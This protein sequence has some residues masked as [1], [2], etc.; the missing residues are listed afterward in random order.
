MHSSFLQ[1]YTLTLISLSPVSNSE[2]HPAIHRWHP[3]IHFPVHYTRTQTAAQ[4]SIHAPDERL[5][6]TILPFRQLPKS[7]AR[8]QKKRKQLSTQ[9]IQQLGATI[10]PRGSTR[11]KKSDFPSAHITKIACN[12]CTVTAITAWSS[13]THP[14]RSS[15]HTDGYPTVRPDHPNMRISC[16]RVVGHRPS[17]DQPYPPPD[18]RSRSSVYP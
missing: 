18:P 8:K 6:V 14:D 9:V 17:R 13:R 2:I 12:A 10:L 15:P 4:K 5:F 16:R 11:P 1:G 7:S 3:M